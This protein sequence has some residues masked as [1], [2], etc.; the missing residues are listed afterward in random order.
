MK[1]CTNCGKLL[2]DEEFYI[3]RGKRIARC[4]ECVKEY[5]REEYK[6]KQTKKQKAVSSK[7]CESCIY[8]TYVGESEME[9]A[10]YYIVNTG[11]R[12]G[13]SIEDCNKYKEGM[14]LMRNRYGKRI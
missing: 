7:K 13:C 8:R 10:C 2:P 12:R 5:Q 14:P 9:V 4:K 3:R 1:R 6:K 11:H